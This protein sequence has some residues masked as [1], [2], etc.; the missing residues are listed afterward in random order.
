MDQNETKRPKIK[1][2]NETGID[3]N[4]SRKKRKVDYMY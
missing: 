3:Q 1:I 4:E 2:K